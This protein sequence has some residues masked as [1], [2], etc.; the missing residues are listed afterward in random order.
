MHTSGNLASGYCTNDPNASGTD[1][2]VLFVRNGGITANGGLLRLCNT[3]VFLMG[4]RPNG[5]LTS[6]QYFVAPLTKPCGD[7]AGNGLIKISGTATQDWTAPNQYDD[8]TGLT[9]GQQKAAWLDKN[10]PEDLAL[11]SESYG[12]ASD[13]QMSGGG[14]MHLVGVFMT[15]NAGPFVVKGGAAQQLSNAQYIASS[16]QLTGGA[17]LYMTV[18]PNNVIT[19]PMLYPF[20]LVR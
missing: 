17:T 15:P 6:I 20:S 16:F 13:W 4:N 1:K 9:S 7:A 10:G 2:A 14:T 18:D 12:T 8:M 19:Y 3:T 11:W 5:C